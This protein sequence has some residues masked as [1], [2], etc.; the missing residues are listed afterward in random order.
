MANKFFKV[1]IP[2]RRVVRYE[3]MVWAADEASAIAVARAEPVQFYN[4]I[5]DEMVEGEPTVTEI[6]DPEM[7]DLWRTAD[8]DW[9][10]P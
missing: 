7:L 6:T 1:S 2:R 4:E 3:E 9:S 10:K 5:T 8:P